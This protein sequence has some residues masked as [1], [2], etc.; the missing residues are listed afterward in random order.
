MVSMQLP[1]Y[2]VQL[3]DYNRWANQRSLAAASR[4]SHNQL[5]KDLGH[6]WG[7]VQAVLVHM[8][9]AEL[10]WLRRWQGISMNALLD[11]SEFPELDVL[12]GRWAEIDQELRAFVASQTA[13]SLQREVHYRNT[14]GRAFSAQLW[15]LLAHLAN[16]G[17]HHRGELAAMFT[18][19][20][21]PHAEEDFYL[22][23]L[24]QN[25]QIQE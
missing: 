19:L 13:E 21:A 12:Q 20:D 14:K 1:E 5:F 9:G 7:S 25:G 10:I 22:Y 17:T 3:Y 8:M 15:Q 16:H 4:L 2:F 24:I 11:P 18:V 23:A 6:S